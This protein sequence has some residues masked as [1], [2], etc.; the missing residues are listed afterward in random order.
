[1]KIEAGDYVL[2]DTGA[3]GSLT[4]VSEHEGNFL[5]VFVDHDEAT[6]FVLQR[7]DR[8]RFWPNVWYVDDHGG[9]ALVFL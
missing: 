6:T 2:S 1:M 7:M 9:T 8:E 3:L 4:A 5:G